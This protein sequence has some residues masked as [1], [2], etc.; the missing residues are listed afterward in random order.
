MTRDFEKTILDAENRG[1]GAWQN[2]EVAFSPFIALF[3][4]IAQV[5][6]TSRRNL[7]HDARRNDPGIAF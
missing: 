4:Q 1:E 5:A 6:K 3:A 2:R 7:A